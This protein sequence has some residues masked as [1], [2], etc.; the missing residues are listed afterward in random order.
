MGA[1]RPEAVYLNNGDVLP[2]ERPLPPGSAS[3]LHMYNGST[4][5]RAMIGVDVL[6]ETVDQF[7]VVASAAKY[8][9]DIARIPDGAQFSGC[10]EDEKAV[11]EEAIL[12]SGTIAIY[13]G[14]IVPGTEFQGYDLKAHGK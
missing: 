1:E 11:P 4:T 8:L 9:A 2:W 13:A 7:R 6:D 14:G 5:P 10:F 3:M 12:F